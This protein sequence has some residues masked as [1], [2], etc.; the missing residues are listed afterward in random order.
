MEK[1]FLDFGLRFDRAVS[2][3]RKYNADLPKSSVAFQNQRSIGDRRAEVSDL[4]ELV[5]VLLLCLAGECIAYLTHPSSTGS[6]SGDLH[7]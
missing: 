7:S 6:S 3:A 2:D 4:R 1:P 5:L